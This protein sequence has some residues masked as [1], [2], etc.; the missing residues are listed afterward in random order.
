MESSDSRSFPACFRPCLFS[1]HDGDLKKDSHRLTQ[2]L[3]PSTGAHSGRV[4]N[5]FFDF[6]AFWEYS[7]VFGCDNVNG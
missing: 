6:Y 7:S 4:A 1:W 2:L 5:S 3:F